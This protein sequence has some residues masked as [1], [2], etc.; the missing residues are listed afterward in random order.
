MRTYSY[1]RQQKP[2]TQSTGLAHSPHFP[3][4]SLS[5]EGERYRMTMKREISVLL[6]KIVNMILNFKI[7]QSSYSVLTGGTKQLFYKGMGTLL[8]L[9]TVNKAKLQDE[10]GH[11]SNYE[12]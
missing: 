3:S 10:Q 11:Y 7:L 4:K 9:N 5:D 12:C 1:L 6:Q 2:L 8:N